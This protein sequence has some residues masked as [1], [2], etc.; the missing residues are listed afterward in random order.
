MTSVSYQQSEKMPLAGLR[1]LVTRQ[2][3]TESSLSGMLESQGASVLIEQMTQ[4]IP[5]VSWDSFDA[6]VPQCSNIDW[7]V[8]TSRNGVIHCLK[9]LKKLELS[10]QKIFSS[11]KIA[12]VGQSTASALIDNGIT[13]ELIPEHFQSEGLIEAFQQQNLFEK[14]CWLIQ[15]ESPRK[16]LRNSLEK[17]GAQIILTP[18]YRNVPAAGDYTY[19]LSELKQQKLDWILFVSP[20]AVQNFHQIL[21][22]GFWDS[23]TAEPKIAC[24]GEITAHAVLKFGWRVQAAPNVQDFEH[25]VQTL[26]EFNLK[27]TGLR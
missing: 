10:A 9:R 22:T 5:P 25:L 24:L 7:A 6:T 17:L 11:I 18:V 23:L 13:P 2:D 1:F 12:C 19:L 8:F 14:R 20:S 4:I 26:C 3:S 15:A 27:N 16:I 21:P